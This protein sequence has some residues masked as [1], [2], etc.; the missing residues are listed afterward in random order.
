MRPVAICEEVGDHTACLGV[1]GNHGPTIVHWEPS[2]RPVSEHLRT[3]LV[4]SPTRSAVGRTFSAWL[5]PEVTKPFIDED[6]RLSRMEGD[7]PEAQKHRFESE[8]AEFRKRGLARTEDL[9]SQLHQR[10]TNAFSVPIRDAS[11]NA[12]VAMAITSEAE[13]LSPDWSGSAPQVLMRA[14][15]DLSARL[16]FAG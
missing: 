13:R 12:I 10:A 16:G 7:S 14:A 11:G 8:L 9:S 4:V 6:L 3:G 2:K 5:L 1:W 15:G